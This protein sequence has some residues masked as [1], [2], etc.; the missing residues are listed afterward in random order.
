MAYFDL[1]NMNAPEPKLQ[2]LLGFK[3]IFSTDDIPI[4]SIPNA[5]A[6]KCIVKSPEQGILRSAVR[7]NNVIGI[8]ITDNELLRIVIEDSKEADKTI[9]LSVHDFTCVDTNKQLRNLH[10]AK[11]MLRFA[12]RSK[13]KV[14]LVSMAND[15]SCL[16]SSMQMLEL[17]MFLSGS[18]EY[19]KTMLAGW[20]Q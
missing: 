8:M 19:A 18:E 11:T 16:L 17:A 14:G 9:F 10:R 20:Y 15:D 5:H 6:E 2:R 13:A 12:M 3:K 4:V 7:K 1:V